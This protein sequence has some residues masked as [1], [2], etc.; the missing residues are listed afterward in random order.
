[1]AIIVTTQND[2]IG[3]TIIIKMRM[4]IASDILTLDGVGYFLLKRIRMKMNNLYKEKIMQV[5]MLLKIYDIILL[6]VRLLLN[7]LLF[8]EHERPIPK[9]TYI[10]GKINT[11]SLEINNK[12]W[13]LDSEIIFYSFLC[14][15]SSNNYRLVCNSFIFNNH[16]WHYEK[17]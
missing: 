4:F 6:L 1:M 17:L 8:L 16:L 15:R 11:F 12:Y 9:L 5:V 7:F 2:I 13:K 10:K 14:Q 3:I